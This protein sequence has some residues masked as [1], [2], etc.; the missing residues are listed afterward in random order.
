MLYLR[1]ERDSGALMMPSLILVYVV[2]KAGE[3]QW[4]T[5]EAEFNSI[6]CLRSFPQ[7][8]ATFDAYKMVAGKDIEEAID[9]ETSGDL[10]AGY[11][12]IGKHGISHKI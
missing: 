8:R 1:L 4:G 2:F 5:D 12:A 6:L 11:L 7:L 3:G 9:D 10:K